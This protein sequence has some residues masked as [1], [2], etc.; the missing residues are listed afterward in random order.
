MKHHNTL[1]ASIL[2]LLLVVSM[3][4]VACAE[5]TTTPPDVSTS[6]ETT[7]PSQ[8]PDSLPDDLDYHGRIFSLYVPD[9]MDQADLYLGSD[10]EDAQGNVVNEAVFAR[11][12][13]VEER[14]KIKLNHVAQNDVDTEIFTKKIASLMM[15]G[16]STYDLY[17][18][19][20]Y[21]MAQLLEIGGFVNLY[22]LEHID[23][24]QPWW[25]NDY[26]DELTLGEGNRIFAVGD[27]F[28]DALKNTRAV[29]Y[30]IDLYEDVYYGEEDLYSIVLDQRWTLDKM[31]ELARGA[32]KDLNSNDTIDEEDQ[33]GFVTYLTLS[34]VDGFVY[35]T[36]IDFAVRTDDGRIEL[37]MIQEKAVTLAEKLVDFF[38]QQGTLHQVGGNIFGQ[39]KSLFLGNAMLSNAASLRD[40][41]SDFGI[42][43]YPKF[44]E[45]QKNYRSLVHDA[46]LIGMVNSSSENLDMVGAV[47]EALSAETYRKLTPAWYETALKTQYT[48]D[49]QS[50]Q[51]IEL[52]HDSITTN[53]IYAY[54]FAINDIGMIYRTLVTYAVKDYVSNVEAQ[55][56]L[57]QG[58]LNSLY[59][60]YMEKNG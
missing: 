14:L 43:P 26:M 2:C 3:L 58:Y 6:V 34:S 57:A 18:G 32:Y 41:T 7:D 56:D 25:W 23:F 50:K 60:I 59:S 22:N 33:L 27:Y 36:D 31:A 19:Y 49:E 15:A 45:A 9:D 38:Y 1:R 44:D 55:A 12:L 40:M 47:L 28:I 21:R 13:A 20:Q 8:H 35:G 5:T 24:E 29:Y 16:D 11:N 30:N 10:A 51:M 39:S 46:T 17:T 37:N 42:I 53:F 54:N 4:A 52:I 48:R